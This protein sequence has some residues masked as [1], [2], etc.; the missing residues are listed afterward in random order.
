[1]DV[2]SEAP[3][4]PGP[5]TPVH[6]GIGAWKQ[7]VAD[8]PVQWLLDAGEPSARWVTLTAE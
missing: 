7:L 8:D 6:D 1:M 4:V 3:M 2:F 5:H